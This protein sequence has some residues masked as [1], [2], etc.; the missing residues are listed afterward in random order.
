MLVHNIKILHE[1]LKHTNIRGLLQQLL[2]ARVHFTGSEGI[3][4]DMNRS[5]NMGSA[6]NE[7]TST[8]L[9]YFET[10]ENVF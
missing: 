7:E 9:R 1:Q 10:Y 2:K 4:V 8:R 5:C 3:D 6:E